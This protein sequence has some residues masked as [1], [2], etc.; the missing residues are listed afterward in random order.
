MNDLVGLI[1]Q[2]NQFSTFDNDSYMGNLRLCGVPLTRKCNEEKG[3]WMQ[4]EEDDDD[5]GFGWRSVV[6]G[7]GSGFMA[8]IGIEFQSKQLQIAPLSAHALEVPKSEGDTW[9]LIGRLPKDICSHNNLQ[10]LKLLDLSSN[11]LQGDIPSSLYQCPQLETIDLSFNSFGGYVPAQISNIT[12][13]KELDLGVN[14]LRDF[15][16]N[17]K[18]TALASNDILQYIFFFAY[19][20]CILYHNTLSGRLP[21]DICS[22]NNL[23]RLK[24]LNLWANELEGDIPL[25]LGQCTQLESIDLSSN[26]F[27]GNVPRE[28][29]NITQLKELR[30]RWNNLKG[31][32]PKEIVYLNNL[33]ILDMSGNNLSGPFPRQIL[34][35]TSL[36]QLYLSSTSLNGMS[37]LLF[38]PKL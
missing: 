19:G 17:G 26:N 34:N 33:E 3:H 20:W 38:K 27:G 36:R 30:L 29:G 1:P 2:S 31:A 37:A 6:M 13:L 32:I 9:D 14:N 8:G 4:P 16:V 21:K 18:A 5:Y 22:N 35:I 15:G 28:I 23:Q 25:S 7:Y 10:R 24:L 11:K 12:L